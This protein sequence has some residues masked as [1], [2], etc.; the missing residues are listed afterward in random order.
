MEF[1]NDGSV[2]PPNDAFITQ[3]IKADANGAFSY[4]MPRAGWWGFAALLEGDMA[5]QSPE[6]A[7]VPV[8]QGALIWVKATDMAGD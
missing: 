5:M 1:I 4:T 8:E 2:T 3:V 6:G 7:D